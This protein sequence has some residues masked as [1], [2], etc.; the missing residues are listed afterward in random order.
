M[1]RTPQT[2][3]EETHEQVMALHMA[4]VDTDLT[5]GIDAPKSS[6]QE[7]VRLALDG[8]EAGL[9]E[10]LADERTRVIKQGLTAPTPI[11]RPQR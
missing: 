2:R 7:I 4:C 9:D 1:S 6:P 10:V 3:K 8:L 5:R 11:Y